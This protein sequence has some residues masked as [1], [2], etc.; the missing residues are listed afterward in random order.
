MDMKI[1]RN[2]LLTVLL[3]FV[4]AIPVVLAQGYED[5][6]SAYI[7]GDYKTAFTILKPLADAG[8]A[9]AQKMMGIM[10]DYGHGVA[11]DPAQALQWYIRSAEQGQTA[12]QYQVGAKYFKGENIAQDYTEAARWWAMAAD[13]GQVDAQFNLGLMYFRGLG[14]TPDDAR[15][16][17]L[18]RRAADQ[19]HAHAQYS[20]A[21]MYAFAR[22]VDKDYD[23]ALQWF[24]KSADQGVAQAQYNL[25]IFHENGYA[26]EANLERA[27]DWYTRAADQ[28][29]EEARAKLVTL[30]SS[31]PTATA[32]EAAI[33]PSG[34]APPA[35]ATATTITPAPVES[36]ETSTAQIPAADTTYTVSEISTN[37]IKREDWVL[38][39][40]PDSY[41]LQ[42]GSVTEENDLVKFLQGH[43]VEDNSA[44]IQVMIDGVTRYNAIYGVYSTYAEAEQAVAGLPDSLRQVSPW[45]RNFGILQKMLN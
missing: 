1:I 15:A 9:Q 43:G 27:R 24:M 38:Q 35:L 28:G 39:Q 10:Y 23:A 6:R 44:Y 41:T 17:E 20:L 21:V 26:V 37:G 25:G 4:F 34:E 5:G 14:V 7:N 45:I 18:F 40:K 3:A 22:G 12:V 19:G 32:V 13:G 31:T 42:I 36:T 8:N 11:P 16:A 29:L 33:T 30:N 2:R